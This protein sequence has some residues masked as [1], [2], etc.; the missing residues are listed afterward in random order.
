MR[1]LRP[2]HARIFGPTLSLSCATGL[3]L[4]DLGILVRRRL[5]SCISAFLTAFILLPT[6]SHPSPLHYIYSFVVS[7]CP[8]PHLVHPVYASRMT[9]TRVSRCTERAPRLERRSVPRRTAFHYALRHKYPRALSLS[10][11]TQCS[12]PVPLP[13]LSGSFPPIISPPPRVSDDSQG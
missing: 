10:L 2:R 3:S 4:S 11:F 9:G 13:T 12:H 8:Y 5:I 6:S 1:A 7:P